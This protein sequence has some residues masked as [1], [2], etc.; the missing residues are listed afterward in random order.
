MENS[1]WKCGRDEKYVHNLIRNPEGKRLL[2][3]SRRIYC[4]IKMDLEDKV[5]GCE[6]DQLGSG[7]GSV[8]SF[9]EEC[10]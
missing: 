4:D 2:A 5:G 10:N 7:H 1:R 6:T 8:A 9:R 3:N